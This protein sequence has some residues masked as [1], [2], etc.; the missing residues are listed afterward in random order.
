MQTGMREGRT[1]TPGGRDPG[2]RRS[3]IGRVVCAALVTAL[4]AVFSL[5]TV[6]R[7]LERI[8]YPTLVYASARHYGVDPLLVASVIRV[9]SK[10]LAGAVSRRGALGLMQV[11]PETARWAVGEMGLEN[12]TGIDLRE[13]ATNVRIGTWYLA[14]LLRH[15]HGHMA[16][17]LAAYNGGIGNV[18]GWLRTGVWNGS[19]HT[20]VRIPFG[21]TREFVQSVE[22][23]YRV[24]ERL[25]G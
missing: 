10:G 22:T 23:A 9:E 1:G 4:V 14:M 17:A 2:R 6:W 19:P 5:R 21:Q 18:D 13:P 11:M 7:R 8:P 12:A 16:P 20:L 24:Y 25:Y 3:G 15:Y